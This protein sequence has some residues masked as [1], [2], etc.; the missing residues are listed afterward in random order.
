MVFSIHKYQNRF[1]AKCCLKLPKSDDRKV[2]IGHLL[3]TTLDRGITA[4]Q[5]V[6]IPVSSTD[7]KVCAEFEIEL[8]KTFTRRLPGNN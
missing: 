2:L 1:I 3:M 4:R 6:C 7:S 8:G 5:E